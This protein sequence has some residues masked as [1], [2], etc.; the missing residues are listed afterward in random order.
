MK[1]IPF[2]PPAAAGRPPAGPRAHAPRGDDFQKDLDAEGPRLNPRDKV[3]LE[4]L[5]A[6]EAAPPGDLSQA[7]SLLS[8]VIAQLGAKTP[9]ELSRLH[10]LDELLCF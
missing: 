10:K 8:G 9:A 1:I 4:N 5:I 2:I 3:G 6:K 7:A